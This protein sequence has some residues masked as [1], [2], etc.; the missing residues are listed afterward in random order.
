[1]Q[2]TRHMVR[3]SLSVMEQNIKDLDTVID[4]L[5]GE[6]SAT[7]FPA[8]TDSAEK[9]VSTNEHDSRQSGRR[10]LRGSQS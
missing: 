6:C 10:P 9:A 1:M 5:V 7:G 4:K 2:P 3:D 8:F